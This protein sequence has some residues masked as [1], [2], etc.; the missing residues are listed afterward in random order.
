MDSKQYREQLLS[1]AK[2]RLRLIPGAFEQF[3]WAADNHPWGYASQWELPVVFHVAAQFGDPRATEIISKHFLDIVDRWAKANLS[4]VQVEPLL[5]HE[6]APGA[7][8]ETAEQR[9][10]RRYQACVDAGLKMPS[11]DY[12]HLPRGIGKLAKAEGITRP[13]FAQDI[14]AHIR[15]L[16]GH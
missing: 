14:K 7:A 1:I 12:A 5:L 16:N 10:K 9:Q 15:R 13:A 2:H 11:D 6:V 4:R 8:G 3:R